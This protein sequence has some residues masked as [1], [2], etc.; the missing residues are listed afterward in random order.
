ML[1]SD[2]L[3][4]LL[5]SKRVRC[6]QR[7]MNSFMHFLPI[8]RTL[9]DTLWLINNSP[10]VFFSCVQY[11]KNNCHSLRL[12]HTHKDQWPSLAPPA[13]LTGKTS[14]ILRA[15]FAGVCPH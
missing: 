14:A 3:M 12:A 2:V 11:R 13:L 5:P 7:S 10:F 6:S 1:N 8:P 15:C 4:P 9:T